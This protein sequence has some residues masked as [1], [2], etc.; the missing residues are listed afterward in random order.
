MDEG[1]ERETA[2]WPM[3]NEELQQWFSRDNIPIEELTQMWLAMDQNPSTKSEIID[4]RSKNDNT[5]L[6]KR[7]RNRIQFGTAGIPLALL[8]SDGRSSRTNGSRLLPHE[9][10]NRHSSLSSPFSDIEK[11]YSRVYWS[12]CFET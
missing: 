4:L 6:E 2:L 9:Q 8:N 10:L 1:R 11:A 3:S 12:T 7:L 5:E